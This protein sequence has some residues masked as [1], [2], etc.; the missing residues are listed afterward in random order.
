MRTTIIL[1]LLTNFFTT[2]AQ[3]DL[4]PGKGK[5]K[6]VFGTTDYKDYLHTGLQITAGP[7]YMLTRR[8]GKNPIYKTTED[9]RPM[10]YLIDP[11]GKPGVFIEVGLAHFTKKSSKFEESI[12]YRFVSYYDWG[13]GFKTLGGTEKTTIDYYNVNGE[14]S[15]SAEGT[16]DFTNGYLYGRFA[17]HKLFYLGEEKKYFID[18]GF[19]LN[20][21][22]AVMNG[23]KTYDGTCFAEQQAFKKPLSLQFQYGLGFGIRLNRRS[24]L[25]P[26]VNVPLFGFYEWR[27]GGGTATK[28]F[29]S[30]YVP[31]FA[32]LKF[33]YLFEKKVK[34]CNTP[35]TEEDRRR[36][37]EFM[38]GQ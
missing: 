13:L 33:I 30:N 22:F 9:G 6:D 23:N 36:N 4:T 27:K 15:G 18:N 29:S 19:G 10:T 5:R 31:F 17:A 3:R 26:G 35:G 20:F 38:L 28:W 32:Q 14:V 7:T 21:D 1:L 2:F 24:Q 12:G 34:G 25:I 16:G 11:A 8:D 37:Q